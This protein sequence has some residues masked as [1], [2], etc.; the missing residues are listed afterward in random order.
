MK[1]VY[2]LLTVV[3]FAGA[4]LFVLGCGDD[5]DNENTDEGFTTPAAIFNHVVGKNWVM[6]GDNIPTHPNGYDENGNF[7]QA[8]QCYHKSTMEATS[9]SVWHVTSVLGTLNDAPNPGDMGT[10]DR[11]TATA[12]VSFD[13]SNVLIEN[14]AE[15]G[16]CFDATFTYTGFAQEGRGQLSADG[17]TMTLELYF[18]G[19]ANGHRCADG[20]VGGS[21]VM[22]NG[23]AFTGDA[24]QVYLMQQ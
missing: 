16:N 3:L 19:Q 13:S 6:E 2:A 11:T 14:V 10:C 9:E 1:S 17:N 4:A 15:D 24:R 12:E 20:A 23:A 18:E 21:G 7:G 22:L 8:T 5:P